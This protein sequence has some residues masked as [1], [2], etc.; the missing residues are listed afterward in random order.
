VPRYCSL[1]GVD[2]YGREGE[3]QAVSSR[4]GLSTD[5]VGA[6]ADLFVVAGKPLLDTVGVEPRGRVVRD[7][8]GSINRTGCGVGGVG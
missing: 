6:P 4:E 1:S 8:V 2:G 7:C 3:S 5:A